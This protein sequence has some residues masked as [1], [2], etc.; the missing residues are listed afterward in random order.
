[1]SD[2]FVVFLD[3]A[4]FLSSKNADFAEYFGKSMLREGVCVQVDGGNHLHVLLNLVEHVVLV[5]DNCPRLNPP[6]N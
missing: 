6:R 2:E 4:H 1:L 3:D 5:E